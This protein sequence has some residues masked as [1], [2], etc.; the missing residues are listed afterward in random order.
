MTLIHELGHGWAHTTLDTNTEDTMLDFWGLE[1]WRDGNDNWKD[2]GTERA[3]QTIAFS[4][5][6]NNPSS[7]DHILQYVCGYEL[8]TGQPLPNPDLFDC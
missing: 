1:S 3:A 2:R 4:L 5:T 6:L 7:N 8:M